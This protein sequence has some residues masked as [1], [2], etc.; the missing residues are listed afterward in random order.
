MVGKPKIVNINGK[1]Q[2]VVYFGEVKNFKKNGK[3]IET[4]EEYRYEGEFLNNLWHGQG[5]LEFLESTDIY[6]GH[7]T[8]GKITGK[9]LFIWTNSQ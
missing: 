7:F 6:E 3:G 5:R 8:N 9:F 1:G 2:K 4:C